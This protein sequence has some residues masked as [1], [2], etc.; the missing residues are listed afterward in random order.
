MASFVPL[1][2]LFLCL[3]VAVLEAKILKPCDVASAMIQLGQKKT[4]AASWVCLAKFASGFN[5][6]ALNGPLSDGSYDFG[7]FQINDKYCKAGSKQSC[8]VSCTDLVKDDPIP[9]A[10]CALKIFD[11]EGFGHWSSW[12]NNCQ[13]IDTSRFITKCLLRSITR[14]G[15]G[16]G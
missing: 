8:G 6:Q 10:K 7:I 11:K 4:K 12:K 3:Q 1:L 15:R 13:N 16:S 9:S 14:D 5:T 2:L